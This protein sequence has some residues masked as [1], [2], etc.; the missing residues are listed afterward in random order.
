MQ[1]SEADLRAFVGP[2][3][4]YYLRGWADAQPGVDLQRLRWNWPAFFLNVVWLLYR[5]MYR[6]FWIGAGVLVAIGLVEGVV[7]AWLGIK[8]P[9]YLDIAITLGVAWYFG[10][11]GTWF[12][13]RHATKEIQ[14]TKVQLPS[15]DA[16]ARAGGIRWL[17]PVVVGLAKGVALLV[18]LAWAAGSAK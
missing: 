3:A 10:A 1:P 13:Y 18:A 6:Y 4:D 5:R 11:F 14:R 16:I 17:W 7:M 9:S 12:Y 2:N 8:P 15:P